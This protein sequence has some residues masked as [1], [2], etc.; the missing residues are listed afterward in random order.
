MFVP[1]IPVETG[2]LASSLCTVKIKLCIPGRSGFLKFLWTLDQQI[3]P[4]RYSLEFCLFI[5]PYLRGLEY[6]RLTSV[7]IWLKMVK[8]LSWV[9]CLWG[10]QLPCCKILKQLMGRGP[11]EE[12]LRPSNNNQNQITSDVMNHL[13]SGFSSSSQP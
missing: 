12:E 4:P 1:L 3:R 7:F 10:R 11:C 9:C 8:F 6:T 5:P 2:I 13:V